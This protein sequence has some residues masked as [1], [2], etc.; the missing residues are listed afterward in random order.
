MPCNNLYEELEQLVS[1]L[2]TISENGT[3]IIVEGCKDERSL[4]ELGV[5]GTILKLSGKK[6]ID[7]AEELSKYEN[8]LI[9]TDFDRKGQNIALRLLE[10]G[11]YHKAEL[12]LSFRR[13][14]K[15]LASKITCNI[16]GLASSY[17]NLQNQ[18]NE[19][20]EFKFEKFF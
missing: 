8:F 3:P 4:R 10:Y 19:N 7:V 18:N 15:N 12:T 6:L 20:T 17:F 13:K 14:F 16:E 9:L 2:R 1:K 11:E 5:R